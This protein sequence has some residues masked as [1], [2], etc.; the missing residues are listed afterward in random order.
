MATI[1]GTIRKYRYKEGFRR[2][3]KILWQLFSRRDPGPKP[4][5]PLSREGVLNDALDRCFW[6]GR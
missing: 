4:S 3:L 5:R 6:S 2:D 1:P